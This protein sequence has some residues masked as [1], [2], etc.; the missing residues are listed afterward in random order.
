ML[1]SF[2]FAIEAVLPIFFLVALGYL[3]KKVGFAPEGFPKAANKLVF[4]VFLPTSLFLNVYGISTLSHID[5]TYV[6]YA[7]GVVL[8][9]FVLGIPCVVA[10]TKHADRRG[11]CLQAIFRSNFALVGLPLAGALF[12]EEGEIV[13]TL[14]AAVTVPLFNVLA[15]IALSLFSENGEKPSIKKMAL[16]ILKNPLILSIGAG[17]V[18]LGVRA[19]LGEAGVAWRLTDLTVIY[20][21]L[22]YLSEVA[23]PLALLVM[24]MQFEFSA[25]KALRREIITATLGRI[26][27]APLLGVGVAYLCFK[28]VFSGSHF[29]AFVAL[30][31]TPVAVSSVP[32][33]QEMGGNTA[34]A[35][36]IV[37]FTTIFS[38]VSIFIASFF[39]RLAGIF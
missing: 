4:R 39:L 15:V 18:A 7:L 14:L 16:G 11:P 13:A 8:L 28:S 31:A 26:C 30:F 34:L 33:T 37:V 29:A 25:V 27:A 1:S 24:G 10:V 23:T 6:W 2:L 22:Q 20:T 12:G 36:Q 35:G 3:L 19:L 9:L 17:F 5:L 32:M 21:P 38:A